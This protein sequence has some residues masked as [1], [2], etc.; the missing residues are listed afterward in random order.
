MSMRAC[1]SCHRLTASNLCPDCKATNVSSD[2]T[3][4]AI[5]LD[6]E[7]SQVAKKLGVTKQGR[8]ALAV[9]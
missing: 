9:R 8:Y 2:W 6:P 4:I 1:R 7:R 5:I 3:G